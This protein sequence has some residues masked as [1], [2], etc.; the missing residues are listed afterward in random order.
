MEML[1]YPS[2]VRRNDTW[3]SNTTYQSVEQIEDDRKALMTE[4]V[5]EYGHSS[6]EQTKK[7]LRTRLSL[8]HPLVHI[9]PVLATG[10]IVQLSFRNVYW[11]D[12]GNYYKDWQ[13]ILQFPAKVHEI[14]IVGSLSAMVL[15]VFRRML[16]SSD[17]IPLGLMVGAFQIGSAEYIMSKTYWK[18]LGHS[19]RNVRNGR[20][21]AFFVALF[22]GFAII[23]S[24]LVGPASAAVLL[25]NLGWWRMKNPFRGQMLQSYVGRDTAELY[26]T[27]LSAAD[28]HSICFTN[29]YWNSLSCPAGGYSALSDW[30]WTRSQEG[31]WYN[32]TDSQ[33]YN[34]TMLSSFS[35]QAQREIVTGI[36]K[37]KNA[38]STD[39]AI[40]ATLHSTVLALTDAFW[41]YVNTNS[42]GKV[43]KAQQ[44]KFILPRTKPVSIPVV[45]VQC[46]SYS[47]AA[48]IDENAD[49][50]F[51]TR[52]M[53]GDFS[54]SPSNPY[55][56]VNW[57][58]PAE[59]WNYDRPEPWNR[60][61]ITWIDPAEVDKAKGRTLPASLAAAVTV[62]AVWIVDGVDAQ[63]SVLMPCVIDARWAKT[64]MSFDITEPGVRTGLTEWLDNANL[65]SG[66]VDVQAELSKFEIGEPITIS[67]DWLRGINDLTNN[68]GVLELILEQFVIEFSTDEPEL[69][70]FLPAASSTEADWKRVYANAVAIVV[71]TTITDWISRTALAGINFTTVLSPEQDGHVNTIDLLNQ[72]SSSA[73]QTQPVSAFD[74]ETEF[75]YTVQRYGW[76]YGL[77]SKTIRFSITTLLIHVVMVIVYFAY[78]LVFWCR[79]KGWT[80]SAWGDIG[81]VLAL[82]N[83]SPPADEFRN[84]GAGIDESETWMTPLRIREAGSVLDKVEL[85]IGTRGGTVVPDLN[86]IQ[87]NKKYA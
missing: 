43:N 35:G 24:F 6:R 8:L 19:L 5:I 86:K 14:L 40:S 56:G 33:H 53:I 12:D 46:Q 36:M 83:T 84:T 21:K 38:S 13:T 47:L 37:T 72:K 44:P 31:T 26:P 1:S 18:P 2:Q 62:P 68:Q 67:K 79:A 73:F 23:Y 45:Q 60:T 34:P 54:K 22:L 4:T 69:L 70:S 28:I 71:S 50:T 7:P 74:D 66:E 87:I 10:G 59:S 3:T 30:A 76:G 65:T 16:L 58:V 20:T 77:G 63:G 75:I 64:D 41:H 85:V 15:H 32:V 17:G 25:P 52:G 9:L 29:D 82:A 39:T 57:T 51:E 49:L 78:S 27:A 48:A 11:A 80:S 42:V 61:N 81:E 55:L